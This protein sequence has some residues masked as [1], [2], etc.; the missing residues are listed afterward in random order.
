MTQTIR[1]LS[2]DDDQDFGL[3]LKTKLKAPQFAVTLTHTAEDFLRQLKAHPFDLLLL[4]RHL[5]ADSPSG[6]AVLEV[7][8]N[9]LK[10][11]VP[12]VMLSH[13][14]DYA[15]IQDCL[16]I[17]ADDYVTKP[18]DEMLLKSKIH[19]LLKSHQ[20]ELDELHIGRI[21][22]ALGAATVLTAS[23][24][25][26]VTELGLLLE[27]K[28][29]VRKGARVKLATPILAEMNLPATILVTAAG[30]TLT[31]GGRYHLAVEFD[32]DD[33]VLLT[34]VRTWLAKA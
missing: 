26:Q 4:D 6:L 15:G 8:K 28:C 23:K 29:F 10:S 3:L 27:A 21:P 18:L 34:N 25:L 17:G 14:D 2:L 31:P 16:E 19:Y 1:V 32:P 30:S 12:V 5:G 20:H 9:R 33:E 22:Q 24:V 11:P 13:H 7:I